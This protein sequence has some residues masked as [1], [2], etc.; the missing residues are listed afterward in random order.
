M[1]LLAGD[2]LAPKIAEYSVRGDGRLFPQEEL[3]GEQR[4]VSMIVSQ[5]RQPKA[6]KWA[7][8]RKQSAEHAA[9]M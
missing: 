9:K 8:R 5:G 3:A 6:T 7:I 4:V 2:F 1:I